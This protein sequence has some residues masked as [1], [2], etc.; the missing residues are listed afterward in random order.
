[1][2]VLFTIIMNIKGVIGKNLI[3]MYCIEFLVLR[4]R[5]GAVAGHTMMQSL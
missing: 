5:V 3:M 2:N 4:D 1:M